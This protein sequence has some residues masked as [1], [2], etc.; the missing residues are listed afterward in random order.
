MSPSLRPLLLRFHSLSRR[1]K[2]A[3]AA[4]ALL[5]GTMTAVSSASATHYFYHRHC[6]Q[7]SAGTLC[8]LHLHTGSQAVAPSSDGAAQQP[9]RAAAPSPAPQAQQQTPGLTDAEQQ[10]LTLLNRE[11]A[12]AGLKPLQ[13]DLQLTQVARLKSRDMIA[14]RY[15]G[16]NSPTYGS[17]F[18]MMQRFGVSY[19]TAAEN[20]A[21]NRTV[22][23]AHISLMNSSGHRANIMNP[24]FTHVGIGAVP[25]GSY[26]MMVTQ[27]FVGR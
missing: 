20:L 9:A 16:H 3:A 2:G 6:A 4:V 27:L 10:M 15:F 13:A 21:G 23:T 24:S 8:W 18:Q 25:G 14:N 7:T 12:R 26:G 1:W 17:P 22:E 19:R 11:R 5:A